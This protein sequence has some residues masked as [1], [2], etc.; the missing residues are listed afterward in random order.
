MPQN[1]KYSISERKLSLR[2]IDVLVVFFSIFFISQNYDLHYFKSLNSNIIS[3]FITLCVYI[4]FFGQIFDLYNL[5]VSSSRYLVI[6]SIGITSLFVT[7][8]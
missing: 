8:F 2:I 4:L 6:R 3:W 5:K 1:P 7:I